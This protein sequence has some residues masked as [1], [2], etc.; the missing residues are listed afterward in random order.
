MN[1]VYKVS[2]STVSYNQFEGGTNMSGTVAK[3]APVSVDI[4]TTDEIE[5]PEATEMDTESAEAEM[6]EPASTKKT[7]RKKT[8]EKPA[9]DKKPKITEL[10][11]LPG[12]G[13]TTADKLREAGFKSLESIAVAS[14]SELVEAAGL[15]DATAKK[16]IAAARNA[17]EI[18][19][20]TAAQ[21]LERRAG[22]NKLST[23]SKEFDQLL[24]GGLESQAI[25]EC[26]GRF[27]SSKTQVAFQL[28]VNVQLPPEQGGLGGSCLFLD[29][30]NTFRPERIKQIA[31]TRGLD[32]GEILKNIHVARAYNADHQMLLA[33]KANEVIEQKNIKIIIV[34]SLMSKFRSEYIGRG[35]LADRQQKIN[36]HLHTLQKWADLYNIP[37][38]VTN[39]VMANPGLLFGDPTTPVGGNIVGHQCTYRIYL[40]KSKDDKRIARLVDSPSLPD[41]ECIFRVTEKGIED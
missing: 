3:E 14:S 13:E 17:L 37:V 32:A 19:I 38:Y 41:G 8:A 11:D 10:E 16:A 35:T 40:R 23:G 36:K 26:Y 15:G 1:G 9:A 20:E 21:I 7:G 33:D 29:T 2:E 4:M 24:D 12:I 25:T 27:G 31:E 6:Q 18:G 39:Q 5:I 22:I 34:D 28:A 30:E